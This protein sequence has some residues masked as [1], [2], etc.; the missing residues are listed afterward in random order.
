MSKTSC[1]SAA[2]SERELTDADLDAVTGG[3]IKA[4][5]NLKW[6]VV[7][8]RRGALDA[9]DTSPLWAPVWE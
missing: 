7:E 1:G 4:M 3:V 6:D 9:P 5:G 8:L 2:S